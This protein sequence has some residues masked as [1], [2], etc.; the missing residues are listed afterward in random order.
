MICKGGDVKYSFKMKKAVQILA[1]VFLTALSFNSYAKS[2]TGIYMT[3]SDY[4]QKHLSYE[5]DNCK[6]L[7]NNSV[8]EMLYITI[9]EHGRKHKLNKSEVYAYVGPEKEVHRFYKNEAYLIAEAGNINVYVQ[10]ERIALS[11]GYEV[12]L[13]Y[14]FSTSPEGPIMPLT[15]ANLKNQYRSP[16]S[17]REHF[18]DLLDQ[19]FSNSDVTAYDKTHGMFKVNYVYSKI[20]LEPSR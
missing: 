4:E 12:K 10:T 3:V 5:E 1:I 18:I 11:K 8:W 9:K 14:Y 16:D 2:P 6:I 13:H 15:I 17:Y 7:L 19:F 20:S